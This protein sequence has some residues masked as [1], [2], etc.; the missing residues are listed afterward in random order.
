MISIQSNCD[1]K[2]QL[3]E[4]REELLDL[5]ELLYFLEANLNKCLKDL[6]DFSPNHKQSKQD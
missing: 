6:E 3:A 1:L 4:T 5:G 2:S